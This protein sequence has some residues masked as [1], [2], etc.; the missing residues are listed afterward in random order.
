MYLDL[1]EDHEKIAFSRLAFKLIAYHGIDLHE[2][3]LFYAALGE[4]GIGEPD[5][6]DDIVIQ[7]ECEA[8]TSPKS[9]R[10][11]L[12][13]LMLLAL[14]DGDLETEERSLLDDMIGAFEFDDETLTHAWEWVMQW[15]QTF[16]AGRHFIDHGAAIP[17]G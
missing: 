4:M 8:F 9:K 14:A 10:I 15:F 17:A 2:E 3:K 12:T 13:E 5:L 1:L 11:A 16:Q 7:T 6:D